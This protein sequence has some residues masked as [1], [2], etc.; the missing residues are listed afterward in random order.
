MIK[1]DQTILQPISN[2]VL[3]TTYQAESSKSGE[4]LWFRVLNSDFVQDARMV[5]AFLQ[6]CKVHRSLDH[7]N[8]LAIREFGSL[9]STHYAV[10][11]GFDGVDLETWIEEIDELLNERAQRIIA[12]IAD[13]F[14]R[15][16]LA[17]IAHGALSPKSVFVN[18]EGLI[19]IADFG[20]AAMI[21][22]AMKA[23][24]QALQP[25]WP[26]CAPE[27]FGDDYRPTTR[28]ELYAVGV[29]FQTLL[30]GSVPFSAPDLVSVL[31]KKL[32]PFANIKKTKSISPQWDRMIS[33]MIHPQA[34][35]RPANFSEILAKLDL[36]PDR[37]L[38]EAEETIQGFKSNWH[39]RLLAYIPQ[40]L[41]IRRIVGSKRR[42]VS[43]FLIFFALFVLILSGLLVTEF[44]SNPSADTAL[45][46]EFVYPL[47]SAEHLDR[48]R[49]D[50]SDL[51]LTQE[52]STLYKSF[53]SRLR[54]S[55]EQPQEYESEENTVALR[56]STAGDRP[57]PPAEKIIKSPDQPPT[58]S[59]QAGAIVTEPA[60]AMAG[61]SLT[62][63]FTAVPFA[64][65]IQIGREPQAHALPYDCS[66]APGVYSLI[67]FA[68]NGYFRWET[69]ITVSNHHPTVI[70]FNPDQIKY[71]QM[72]VVVRNALDFGFV[73]VTINSGEP[74]TTPVH[75]ELP[76]AH[77]RLKF[78]RQG[79]R[80][81]P[82]DTVV[83]VRV[84]QKIRASCRLEPLEIVE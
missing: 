47:D 26:Y 57:S 84:G 25:L 39:E 52:D 68:S 66:L 23:Y 63:R 54:S 4:R 41:W 3:W 5:E 72:E 12:Q 80:C 83:I 51:A 64:D 42:T 49:D 75:L 79:F 45:Y 36:L 6:S 1:I 69:Q 56:R 58:T 11:E 15:S 62:L 60:P 77:H 30:D 81:H 67:Y 24:P 17:G 27:L 35:N 46:E 9:G 8:C 82:A 59:Q 29:L 65:N 20:S 40:P 19:R 32:D 34:A 38:Q 28:S 74:L 16:S 53:L 55:G 43:L 31:S 14:Y 50:S 7:P 10:Y 33:R 78:H 44:S 48:A 76:E 2:A 13:L 61:K 21:A 22:H 37:G 18:S 70:A 71:G 73:F